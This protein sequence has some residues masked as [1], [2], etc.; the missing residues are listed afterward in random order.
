MP[1]KSTKIGQLDSFSDSLYDY[2]EWSWGSVW[3][4]IKL[5]L[6]HGYFVVGGIWFCIQTGSHLEFT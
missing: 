4:M 6:M 1:L 3:G 2:S 5:G